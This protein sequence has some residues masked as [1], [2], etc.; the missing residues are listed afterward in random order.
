MCSCGLETSQFVFVKGI[1]LFEYG[2]GRE[3]CQ[4]LSGKI[5]ASWEEE[6]GVLLKNF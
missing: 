4:C 5:L 1:V 6:L 2:A 3:V